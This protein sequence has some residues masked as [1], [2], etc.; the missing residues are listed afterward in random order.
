MSLL[1]AALILIPALSLSQDDAPAP[2]LDGMG[3]HKF[4]VSTDSRLA[5]QYFDQGFV[6]C[7]GFNNQEAHRSFMYA[8]KLDPDCAMAYWGAALALGPN[9]NSGMSKTKGKKAAELIAEAMKRLDTATPREQALIVALDERYSLDEDAKRSTLDRAYAEAMGEVAK[10]YPDDDDVLTMTAESLMNLHKWNYWNRDGTPKEW[11]TEI[12]DLLARA[13]VINPW[14]PGANHFTIH[15]WEGSK[16]PE[17]AEPAADRLLGLVPGVSHLQHMP[18]HIYLLTGRYHEGSIANIG[19]TAAY[20]RYAM[21]CTDMGLSPIGGYKAHNWD[22]LWH[23]ARWEGRGDLALEAAEKLASFVRLRVNSQR[24]HAL[25]MYTMI[26][27]M[28]WEEILDTP[29]PSD[30]YGYLQFV[31][32]YGQAMAMVSGGNTTAASDHLIE[33]RTLADAEN[34]RAWRVRQANSMTK[35]ALGMVEAEIAVAAKDYD[36]AIAALQDARDVEEGLT[37][38]ETRVWPHPVQ[39]TLGRVLM[40]AGR[41]DEAEA[42]YRENLKESPE[43]G[44]SL[45]GLAAVL[46]LQGK[47]AESAECM[48]RYSQ[49]W[50]FS[51]VQLTDSQGK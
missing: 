48:L 29:E 38:R 49:A 22:F 32:H 10:Q 9:L 20:D 26:Q 31:W 3:T 43:N 34:I 6:L 19:A 8:T 28:R 33:M 5:Q 25:P 36:A 39:I 2:L 16:T 42:A 14:N 41:L 12:T 17:V 15:S 37:Y 1:F 35:I 18:S 23:C 27:F 7:Y 50:Q 47:Q 40:L 44:W 45:H 21:L 4:P 30:E 13:L 24:Q 46:K 51:D 11:T